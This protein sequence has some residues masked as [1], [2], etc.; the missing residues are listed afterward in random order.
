MPIKIEWRDIKCYE[1]LYQVSNT[2]LVKSLA[3]IDTHNQ[4]RNERILSSHDDGCGY[5]ILNLCK[6]GKLKSFKVH[7]L[8]AEAFLSK[9]EGKT[10]V[11]HK[12]ENKSNNY[13]GNLE[14]CTFLENINYGTRNSRISAKNINNKYFSK[15]VLCVSTGIIYKSINE[16][17][18]QTGIWRQN[19]SKC[20]K[21]L[22]N[23]AGDLK[24]KMIS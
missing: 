4:P 12:D 14:W 17:S 3:R 24:W 7:R 23:Y 19:I 5:R 21:G 11:N 13:V 15:K 16:A 22:R 20:C 10:F 18:R 9:I 1:G 2:G 6:N 8:V